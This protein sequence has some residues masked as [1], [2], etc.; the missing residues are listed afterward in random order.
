MASEINLLP[1]EQRAQEQRE[2]QHRSADQLSVKYSKPDSVTPPTF[3]NNAPSKNSKEVT[4]KSGGWWESILKKSKSVNSPAVTER[5]TVSPP[6]IIKSESVT[7]TVPPVSSST[8]TIKTKKQTFS[9]KVYLS[10]LWK[11]VLSKPVGSATEESGA[12][13]VNLIPEE[14]ITT[15]HGSLWVLIGSVMGALIVV[16]GIFLW[17]GTQINNYQQQLTVTQ[18]QI[19]NLV[20]QIVEQKSVIEGIEQTNQQVNLTQQ[21]LDNHIY[22]TKF[23]Q[24]LE[25]VTLPNVYYSGF[26]GD[27]AGKFSLSAS[28]KDYTTLAQQLLLLQSN[29]Q[30]GQ[31]SVSEASRDAEGWVNFNLSFSVKP[32]LFLKLAVNP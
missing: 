27:I 24:W 15:P 32:S 25:G 19:T 14:T 31:V 1:D 23:F 6:K 26:M 3:K 30:I 7:K 8:D 9:L 4:A 28:A 2:L 5:P 18:D 10:N 11:K 16:A 22:W 29:D 21:L 20:E 13:E 12:I 17:L